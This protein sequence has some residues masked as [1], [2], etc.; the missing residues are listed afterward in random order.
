MT[1]GGRLL[2]R[3][4]TFDPECWRTTHR[5]RA[6]QSILAQAGVEHTWEHSD[7]KGVVGTGLLM[8][9]GHVCDDRCKAVWPEWAT[10]E[11]FD[12]AYRL[13]DEI[14]TERGS[15]NRREAWKAKE[16]R[17]ANERATRAQEGATA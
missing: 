3:G 17:N 12:L 14:Q 4:D 13:A 2:R 16:E 9:E 7:R 8:R 5:L 15:W 10:D 1:N 11:M 6:G